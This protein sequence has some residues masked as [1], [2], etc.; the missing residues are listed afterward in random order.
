MPRK[1][2]RLLVISPI[3][4]HPQ[5]E[6]CNQRLYA[7]LNAIRSLGHDVHLAYVDRHKGDMAAM[8]R[9]WGEK[10]H[11]VRYRDPEGRAAKLLV[12]AKSR[13]R[14]T[15]DYDVD[16]WF[17]PAIEEPIRQ[18]AVALKPDAVMVEYVYM[19]KAL[20]WFDPGV[21]RI[22]DTHDSMTARH[23]KLLASGHRPRWF[24]TTEKEEGRGLRRADVVVAIQDLERAFFERISGRRVVTV[25]HL[26]HV[27]DTT[28]AAPGAPRILFIGTNNPSNVD[29][30][31]YLL[32]EILP[33]VRQRLP[34]AEVVLVGKICE[35][36]GDAPG[37]R[38][39]GVVLNL[40]DAYHG[41]R[42]VVNP[43]RFGTGLKIKNIEALGYCSPLVT[44]DVG[45]E[46]MEDGIGSAF[47]VGNGA[48][49]L[50]DA[51]VAI[52]TEH[53]LE[54]RLRAGGRA[55]A[56][57]WNRKHALA[58]ANLLEVSA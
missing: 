25:G 9:F 36:V 2:R 12:K 1:G 8:R 52:A 44:T 30:A 11:L 42:M 29:A 46:G 41:A 37:C 7:M 21:L 3:P 18:L 48:Q 32:G 13:L 54:A 38:K 43:V 4:T 5:D 15:H 10:L 17:D 50:A 51:L 31:Q 27:D 24:S 14:V 55:Y 33:L 58:L 19:S 57:T 49:A 39:L 53:G 22:I 6:G 47:L 40:A 34:D 16:A 23:A 35:A 56:E 28:P 26:V 20:E 45:A